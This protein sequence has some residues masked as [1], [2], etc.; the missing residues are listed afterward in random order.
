[1]K[2]A[3]AMVVALVLLGVGA[4]CSSEPRL[5]RGEARLVPDEG[6]RVL[7]GELGE[8]L[9]PTREMRTLHD[10]AR[11]RLLG[12]EARLSL[13][14]GGVLELRRGTEVVLGE[15][16]TLVSGELLVVPAAPTPLVVTVGGTRV[17]ALGP[18]RLERD[19]AL[20]VA[21]Y[22]VGLRLE[23][24]GRR[25][26]VA[27][28][29]QASVASLGDVP[30][31]ARPLDY[32]GG[33]SWDRRFLGN[34][35]DLG[36]ELEAR[37]RGFSA[38]LGPDEGRTIGFYRLLLPALEGEP[39]FGPSSLVGNRPPG[40]MLVG[41]ALALGGRRGS[42][43]TRLSEVFS[44]RDDGAD[45]GL[46]A[47]EQG[48][49]MAPGVV[50]TVDLAISRASLAFAPPPSPPATL[51]PRSGGGA[52]V[53]PGRP[54]PPGPGAKGGSS[55]GPPNPA[56]PPSTS[57]SPSPGAGPAPADKPLLAPVVDLLAGLLPGI[58]VT[59]PDPE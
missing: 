6:A 14:G 29:R 56:S 52:P 45:W 21:S 8:D 31:R 48:V 39:G 50:E 42:F 4:G 2:R 38:S 43:V 35:I 22:S 3:A 16:P 17:T 19:L 1:M 30:S 51:P 37:S 44:F 33:D 59:E 41:T 11:V 15:R 23:S 36:A 58:V 13:P 26:A 49:A 27:G 12:G 57:P 5:L 32:D 20:S 9:R 34:A 18:A 46:V 47:L 25:L 55:A 53:P 7:A 10:G 40:E 28:L 54:P 24:A